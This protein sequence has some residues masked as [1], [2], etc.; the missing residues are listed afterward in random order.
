MLQ[1]RQKMIFPHMPEKK[2]ANKY[3]NRIAGFPYFFIA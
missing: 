3:V 1:G 2:L